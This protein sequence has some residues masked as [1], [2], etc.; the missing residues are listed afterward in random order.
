MRNINVEKLLKS[1]NYMKFFIHFLLFT[2]ILNSLYMHVN[3]RKFR[4]IGW[5]FH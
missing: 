5:L 3:D 2:K 1:I 4:T